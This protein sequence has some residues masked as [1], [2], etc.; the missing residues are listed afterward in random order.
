MKELTKVRDDSRRST[1]LRC[2]CL[3]VPLSLAWE[4]MHLPLYTIWRSAGWGPIS[5]DVLHC[6][7]GDVTIGA[8]VL[9]LSIVSVGRQWP[10]TSRSRWHVALLAI[11]L[12]V[13]Y[14]IFSEWLN[15]S[16][17][18]S[19]AYAPLMP[20]VPFLGTGLSPLLQWIV[21]P[22]IAL[23]LSARRF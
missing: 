1:F 14:T 22:P 7:A 21:I 8:A 4:V 9:S 10:Y 3:F 2:L 20:I 13:G 17:R 6:T 11:A 18:G 15:V 23:H 12:G 16:V 19:W 5:F